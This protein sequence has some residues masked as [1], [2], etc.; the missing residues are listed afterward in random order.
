[1]EAAGMQQWKQHVHAA[2]KQHGHAPWTSSIDIQN[3]CAA[4]RPGHAACISPKNIFRS[5]GG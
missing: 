5:I 1:M 4:L 2:W 3:G